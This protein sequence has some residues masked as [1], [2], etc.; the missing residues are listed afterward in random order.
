MNMSTKKFYETN[1]F[2]KQKAEWDK[3]LASEGLSADEEST[4]RPQEFYTDS[5]NAQFKIKLEQF[6]EKILNEFRFATKADKRIFKLHVAGLSL[7][8]IGNTYNLSQ[9]TI[10]RKIDAIITEAKIKFNEED[11]NER[12]DD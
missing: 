3:R 6:Y 8:E 4:I 1:E 2:K 12:I 9:T 7:R 10:K 5:L 11:T